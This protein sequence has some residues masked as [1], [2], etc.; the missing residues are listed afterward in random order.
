[1][2]EEANEKDSCI[3]NEGVL[4]TLVSINKQSK[5]IY[6]C[7][8]KNACGKKE[9]KSKSFHCNEKVGGKS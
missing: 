4:R 1:M 3:K 5:F 9:Q 6:V 8:K 7:N 2:N